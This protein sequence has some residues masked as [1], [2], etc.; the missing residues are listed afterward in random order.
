MGQGKRERQKAERPREILE[1]ALQEFVRKGYMA[2]RVE[3]IAAK[4]GVTKGTIYFYFETKEDIFA[5]VIRRFTPSLLDQRVPSASGQ[6]VFERLRTYLRFLYSHAVADR[7]SREVFHLLISDGRHFPELL[8]RHFSEFLEP[9]LARIDE[10]LRWGVENGEFRQ[11]H[12]DYL[13]QVVLGP[14]V[15][16]SVWLSMFGVRKPIDEERFIGTHLNLLLSGLRKG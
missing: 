3:D 2:T 13:S 8:D 16:L 6:S 4:V 12:A 14:T 1:A 7:K 11:D 9:A 5:Q 15:L 10:L